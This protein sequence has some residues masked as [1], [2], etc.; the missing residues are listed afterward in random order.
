M[1]WDMS[2]PRS[3]KQIGSPLP[4]RQMGVSPLA[5]IAESKVLRSGGFD[6]K[7][8]L[9]DMDWAS[10]QRRAC[11][12]ANRDLTQEEWKRYLE[13]YYGKNRYHETCK[14]LLKGD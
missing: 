6:G 2:D 7:I 4:A 3:A 11:K 9:W 12:I 13:P 8:T 14:E 1:L 5:F 10:L